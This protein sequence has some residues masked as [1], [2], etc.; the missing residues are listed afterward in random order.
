[1]ENHGLVIKRTEKQEH[2]NALKAVGISPDDVKIVILTHLHWDHAGCFHLFDN[3]TFLVQKRELEY[4]IAPFPCH[5]ALYHENSLGKPMFVDYLK[6]IEMIDGDGQ[7]EDGVEVIFL[8][9]HTPGFQG[10]SVRTEEGRYVIAGDAVG[11]F[12]SWETIPHVPTGLFTSLEEC[13]K[14]MK[15]IERIADFVLPGHDMKVFDK[16]AYP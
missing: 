16:F 14:S 4:A 5:H 8:P 9:G 10:V 1:M 7:V 3:A 12:E 15:K 6:R 2:V 11:M 13:Y